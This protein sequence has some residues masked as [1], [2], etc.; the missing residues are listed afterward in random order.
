MKLCIASDIHGS[1][2]YAQIVKDA[3]YKHECDTLLLLGDLLYHG[4][5]NDLPEA[6][7]PKKVIEIL[8]SLKD[9]IISV[10]GNCEAEVDQM[11]LDFNV[12][13][14]AT[15]IVM[16]DYKIYATHGHHHNPDNLPYLNENDVFMFG[17]IH[18]P[19]MEKKDGIHII[20]PGSITLPKQNTA[21]SYG[22]L[23]NKVFY[24]YDE[25]HTLI[26]TYTL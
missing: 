25:N 22:V 10:R 17:H 9:K 19:V 18:I 16:E 14:T 4:P 11:V 1:S 6:Y 26:T 2:K 15:Q 5:R 23:E 8:N 12:M 7:A 24:L 3:F 13:N 21:H 20:N